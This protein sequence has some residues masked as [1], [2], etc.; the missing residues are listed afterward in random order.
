ML[1]NS[2]KESV[3]GKDWAHS[4]ESRFDFDIAISLLDLFEYFRKAA[5]VRV[6]AT[7]VFQHTCE[8]NQ[9]NHSSQLH[10]AIT[11]RRRQEEETLCVERGE[12]S[13]PGNV[14]LNACSDCD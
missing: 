2:S 4:E 12:S 5:E 11:H 14:A 6:W 3:T 9:I 13:L 8:S 7:R 10:A 1:R